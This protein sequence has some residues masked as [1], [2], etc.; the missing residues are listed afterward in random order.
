MFENGKAKYVWV[1]LVPGTFY[2]FVTLTYIVNAKIG[3]NLPWNIA[4]IIG[5]ALAAIYAVS[6]LLYGKKRAKSK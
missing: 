1:P 5:G 4:Y 6:I 2:A 3:F